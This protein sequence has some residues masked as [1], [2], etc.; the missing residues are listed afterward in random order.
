MHGLLALVMATISGYLSGEGLNAWTLPL[1]LLVLVA[2]SYLT[3]P[4]N[5]R[6]AANLFPDRP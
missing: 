3:R 6:V 5:R 1:V 2:V 4:P